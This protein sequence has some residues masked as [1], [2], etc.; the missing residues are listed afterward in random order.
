MNLKSEAKR[1]GPRG[2]RRSL[3]QTVAALREELYRTSLAYADV[4]P[5][6]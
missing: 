6:D 1:P 4:Q 3:L 5:K 2:V